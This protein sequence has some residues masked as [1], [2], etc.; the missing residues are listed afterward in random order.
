MSRPRLRRRWFVAFIAAAVAVAA[1]VTVSGLR[2]DVQQ[3]TVARAGSGAEVAVGPLVAFYGD[4]YTKGSAASAP[5]A[6]WSSLVAQAEGWTEYNAGYPGLGFVRKRDQVGDVA[7]DV[8]AQHPEVLIIA[9]GINDNFEW[10]GNEEAIREAILP[11]F[12][13]LRDGLPGTR[14]VVVEPWWFTAERPDSLEQ[15]I[16][17]VH[18]AA[19][20]IDADYISGASHWL[21][22]DP[23]TWISADGLHPSDAG[24][25]HIAQRMLEELDALSPALP[26]R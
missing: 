18:D 13:R 19:D 8:I 6:R 26:G 20:T 22:E 9:L 21:D 1:V 15:I 16:G 11:E 12:Q 23:A 24:Y 2:A 10:T 17:W 5:A 25:A 7:A 14:I 3:T 4:S